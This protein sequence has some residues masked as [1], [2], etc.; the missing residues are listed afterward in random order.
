MPARS[1]LTA[2]IRAGSSL[3]QSLTD[4]HAGHSP[5]GRRPLVSGRGCDIIFIPETAGGSSLF[6]FHLKDQKMSSTLNWG[7]IGTGAIARTFAAGLARSKTGKLLAI[8]S[9]SQDKADRFGQ[10]LNVERRYG[11]YEALLADKDVQAVYIAT[12]HPHHAEWAIKAAEAKKHILCEKPIALNHAAATA[13]VEAA[14]ANDV[15]LMEA[16]MYRCHPQ[17]AKLVELIRQN[18]IG[19]VSL[20]QATFSFHAQ[21]NPEGRLFKN[22][23]GGGGILDVGCY[24]TSLARLVAGAAMGKDFAEPIE[25]KGTGHIGEAR[26]DEWAVAVLRF[27]GDIVAQLATGVALNQ[28]N[29]VRIY[30]SEGNIIIPSAWIP[31]REGGSVKIIV[32]RKGEPQPR[33]IVIETDQHLYG[34]EADTVA[35]NIEKRQAPPPAMTWDDTLGNMR[36]LDLWRQSFGM[37]YDEEKWENLPTVHRRPLAVTPQNNMKYGQIAGVSKPVSRLVMGVDNHTFPPSCAV[38]W[39]DFFERGGNCWD[40]AYIYGGGSHERALGAW[41]KARGLRQQVVILDKGAHSPDCNPDALTRQ[42]VQ[43]LERLQTDYVD[44]YMM[45]RDNPEI[46]V[47]EF[48]DCLNEHVKA[49]RIRAF[50]G[51]NWSI[52][53]IQKAQA[54]ARRKGLA[55]FAAVSNNFSLA[56]MVDPVWAGCIHS[57]DRKSRAFFKRTQLPLMPWSSQARGFFLEGKA[58]PD[59]LDDQELVRCWYSQDNFKRLERAKELAAKKGVLPINIALAYVLCQ[60]FPTF[61]LIGPRHLWE[62]RTSVPALGIEL[63]AKELKWLNVED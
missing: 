41:V 21:F 59:K 58:A 2:S 45:H 34:I 56:R 29:T 63:T 43:S 14:R 61:P 24:T 13:I 22:A 28:D 37:I 8:A 60:P 6:L 57:S 62:T 7:I 10:E 25:V 19:Q 26:S 4:R 3:A 42:L 33:E 20:I 52:R 18:V 49:G 46:P 47:G 44:I 32:N 51:S 53:R 31:A 5:R 16:F 50:G 48:I 15:F 27:P 11:S 9:R 55:G 1:Q 17:T 30:G 12:P 23:L 40:T 38:V 35:A 54:Y 36:T 39:D